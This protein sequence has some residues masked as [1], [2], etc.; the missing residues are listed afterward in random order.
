MILNDE[1]DE[2]ANRLRTAELV[3][4][5]T[6]IGA[7]VL[8]Y[9]LSVYT[10]ELNPFAAQR[11]EDLGYPLTGA[12]A[13]A[14]VALAFGI[15]RDLETTG[16]RLTDG[17]EE[18]GIPRGPARHLEGGYSRSALAG[19]IGVALV[20]VFDLAI[21]LWRLTQVGLPEATNLSKVASIVVA[22]IAIPLSTK[23]V[24]RYG[25]D[26][27]TIQIPTTLK[28]SARKGAH[29]TAIVSVVL[30]LVL[31]PVVGSVAITSLNGAAKAAPTEGD[32]VYSA[33]QD[34]TVKAVYTADG[35]EKWS[36]SGHTGNVNN[37][38]TGP[39]GEAV[40]SASSDQTVR[41]IDADTGDQLWSF[42]GH[43]DSVQGVYAGPSGDYVYSSADDGTVRKIH[44]SNGS[45][46]M[47][48]STPSVAGS[49]SV[50]P[51]GSMVYVGTNGGAV[52]AY[53][54]SN[55]NEQWT[56]GFTYEVDE[57]QA[58][59]NGEYVYA[60]GLDKS[61]FSLNTADGS[62]EWSYAVGDNLFGVAVNPSGDTVYAGGSNNAVVAVNT[63]DGSQKWT[64]TSFSSTIYTL[65]GGPSG[66]KVYAGVGNKLSEI[67][68]ASQGESF[69]FT[70][71][72]NS[73]YGASGRRT[74]KA[75]WEVSGSV[76][77]ESGNGIDGAT[78][79]ATKSGSTVAT[80]TTSADGSYSF[81]LEDGDYTVTATKSG[82]TDSS[83]SITVSG[84]DIT[85]VDFSIEQYGVDGT[86]TAP[87]GTAVGGATVEAID[88]SGSVAAS[89][90][91]SS[92]GAYSLT[93]SSGTY[94]IRVDSSD[95]GTLSETVDVSGSESTNFSYGRELPFVLQDET[96]NGLF[97]DNPSL[98]VE[99]PGGGSYHT[100]NHNDRAFVGV[101]D[102]RTYD[103]TVISDE[104][105][106][107][108]FKGY[109]VQPTLVEGILYIPPYDEPETTPTPT[110]TATVTTV[111]PN[112]SRMNTNFTRLLSEINGTSFGVQSPEPMNSINY[113][114]YNETGDP[115]Y[116]G[117]REF[118]EPVEYYVAQIADNLTSNASQGAD[119]EIEYGGEFE[120]GS[121]FN[122]STSLSGSIFGGGSS[123]SGAPAGPTGSSGGGNPF[124]GAALVAGVGL[125]AYRVFGD[126][127]L[128]QRV[129][130]AAQRLRGR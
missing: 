77:D 93:L 40:Y 116:N 5:A 45:Q 100:F 33:S 36:F 91:T 74:I 121:S 55:G 6:T 8:T 4:Q 30:L 9:V 19:A 92:T 97:S 83:Q 68:T 7:L 52:I 42:T 106:V 125:A 79:E 49:V 18:L 95:Y 102:N 114:I 62:E 65:G 1:A 120:N 63:A 59:P 64:S 76:S 51:D 87:D 88:S 122:G 130:N 21:N 25:R 47:S 66:E 98:T 26:P 80:T 70:G 110:A 34:G 60:V 94:T 32:V 108:E 16:S 71:H 75:A 46:E 109:E 112:K 37:V 14:A 81:D 54:S 24:Q 103:L 17:L 129:S 48:F 41:A 53:D 50:S 61:V 99:G 12:L 78:V 105:A 101:Q 73:V 123:S 104:P 84:S 117:S 58:G 113:T 107:Y 118:D 28:S 126:G 22:C 11:F 115:V 38:D 39:S 111:S 82:Y 35:T 2:T 31:S 85:G 128:G 89:T 13:I 72:T 86:V 57:V 127:N 119:G 69:A 67:D 29:R 10:V 96:E 44:A 3:A 56:T 27:R 90:S 23:L 43:T 20:G 15:F 124:V